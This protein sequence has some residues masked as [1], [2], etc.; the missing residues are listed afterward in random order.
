M[1]RIQTA[2]FDP[3]P[4]QFQAKRVI[5]LGG[6]VNIFNGKH[7]WVDHVSFSKCDDGLIDAVESSSMITIS[8]NYMTQHD[9]AMLLGHSDAYTQDKVMQVTIAFNHFGEGLV[10]RIPR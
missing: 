10:Q 5:G 1:A 2:K 6:A 7:I 3:K 8:N 9:K 4:W